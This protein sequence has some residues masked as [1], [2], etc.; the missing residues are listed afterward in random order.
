MKG[1]DFILPEDA[2]FPRRW[3]FRGGKTKEKVCKPFESGARLPIPKCKGI[4]QRKREAKENVKLLRDSG[5][6]R[7]TNSAILKKREKKK[8]R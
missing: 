2:S 6:G 3:E 1:N 7:P 4:S 5:K 8:K